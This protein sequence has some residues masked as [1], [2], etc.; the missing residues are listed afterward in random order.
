LPVSCLVVSLSSILRLPL[1]LLYLIDPLIY[2]N[3]LSQASHSKAILALRL[4][5][6]T[7]TT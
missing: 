2:F 6:P 4:N 1:F 7:A 5:D 3:L